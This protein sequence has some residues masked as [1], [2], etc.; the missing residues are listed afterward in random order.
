MFYIIYQK[1]IDK[2][3]DRRQIMLNARSKTIKNQIVVTSVIPDYDVGA[4]V[5][6][7][8]LTLLNLT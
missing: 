6:F 1:I 7:N 4:D 8:V 2:Y 5:S 3:S